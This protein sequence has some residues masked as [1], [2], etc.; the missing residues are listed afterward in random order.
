MAPRT[1]RNKTLP[2]SSMRQEDLDGF[3]YWYC[4]GGVISSPVWIPLGIV[5]EVFVQVL[6]FT[7]G[8]SDDLEFGDMFNAVRYACSFVGMGVAMG[9]LLIVSFPFLFVGA[10]IRAVCR[11]MKRIWRKFVR[12]RK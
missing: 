5:A 9:I 8:D 2:K 11:G 3:Y 6:N 7:F 12:K 10:C 1:G 4:V